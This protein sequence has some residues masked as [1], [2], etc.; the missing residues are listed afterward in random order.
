MNGQLIN[1]E[2]G[3]F[4]FGRK[5]AESEIGLSQQKIRTCLKNLEKMKILTS[6]STNRFTL[7]TVINW[8]NYQS[9]KKNQPADQPAINQPSTSS[10]PA[11]NHIQECNTVKNMNKEK[12]STNVLLKKKELLER[13]DE[14]WK[15]YPK[16]KGK[17]QARKTWVKIRP[18]EKLTE[19]IV[20]HLERRVLLDVDWRKD[21]GQFIP[22]PSSWLN[23]EGW[24]DEYKISKLGL[25]LLEEEEQEEHGEQ[26][27]PF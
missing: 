3:Q 13:F 6:R 27:L 7:V 2:V 12:E 24:E 15:S 17:G 8:E 14:F 10:Q 20:E 21:D 22:H 26:D 11:A 25:S 16:K 19:K 23:D 5:I 4:V 18:S 9:D 1:L